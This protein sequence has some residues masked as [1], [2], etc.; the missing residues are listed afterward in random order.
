MKQIIKRIKFLSENLII[1]RDLKPANILLDQGVFKIT[2]FG[3]NIFVGANDFFLQSDGRGE[4]PAYASPQNSNP[5]NIHQKQIYINLVL[6][7]INYF[8]T[9]FLLVIGCYI[10]SIQNFHQKIKSKPFQCSQIQMNGNNNDKQNLSKLIDQMIQHEE[11]DRIDLHL[12]F[13]LD[14]VP[15]NSNFDKDENPLLL[16]DNIDMLQIDDSINHNFEVDQ[17]KIQYLEKYNG[18]SSI[19]I[20]IRLSKYLFMKS[21][22]N[23]IF[24]SLQ[25][26][27]QLPQDFLQKLFSIGQ[28]YLYQGI[29]TIGFLKLKHLRKEFRLMLSP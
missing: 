18:L 15:L 23:P 7:S 10:R 24:I 8:Q 5:N 20:Q 1:H 26:L 2:D 9:S 28:S 11:F 14:E 29:Y 22:F 4:S 13:Q 6:Y 21:Q 25:Q 17:S 19:Q 12:I 27:E 3:T 16:F